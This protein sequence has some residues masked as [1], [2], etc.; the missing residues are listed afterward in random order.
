MEIIKV[1]KTGQS[2]FGYYLM[3]EGSNF[4]S[5]TEEVSKFLEK[6]IPCEIEVTQKGDRGVV[7]R[8]KV[9]GASQPKQNTT[10]QTN[11]PNTSDAPKKEFQ[12]A[13]EYYDN[14]QESIVTQFC[15]REGLRL[16]NSFNEISEEKIKPT[17]S[18]LLTN[19]QVIKQVYES[20]MK[21]DVQEN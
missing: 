9:V 17:M 5:T 21:K 16:I 20:L 1:Q 13:N 3:D 15:I 11:I 8:V 2:K 4:T 18:N 10:E 12:P 6:Q 14:R 19:T 7:E